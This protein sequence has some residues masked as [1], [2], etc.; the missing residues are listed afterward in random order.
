MERF[1]K[2]AGAALGS[3][4]KTASALGHSYI[5]SEH[6]LLGILSQT[7]SVGAR[8]LLS[9]GITF[10]KVRQRLLE[11]VGSNP[12]TSLTA[13]DMTSRTRHI[14]EQSS[15]FAK[16]HGFSS[17]GTEHIL[18]AIASESGCVAMQLL[19]ALGTDSKT[20]RDCITEKLGLYDIQNAQRTPPKNYKALS[21]YAKNLVALAKEGKIPKLVGRHDE[22]M[23][24]MSILTRHTK[25]NPCL[26]GEPGV[27]KTCIAE[28]L[29]LAI[30]KNDVPEPLTGKQIFMLDLTSMIAGSKYR[31][32]FEERLRAVLDEAE[33]NPEIILFV[34]EIHI[35]VGAGAAEGAIDACNILKPALARGQIKMIGATTLSEYKKHIEKDKALERRFAP[36]KID[37]PTASQTLEILKGLRPSL[38]AHHNVTITDGALYSAITLSSRYIGD[39]FL[40]DKAIDLIDE[41][42][43]SVHINALVQKNEAIRSYRAEVEGYIKSGMYSKASRIQGE[44]AELS[45]DITPVIDKEHIV[46]A[47]SKWTGIPI[48]TLGSGGANRLVTLA[49]TLSE[50]LVGQ[51]AAIE[52]V[53]KTLMFAEA[54]LSDPDKPTASFIFAGP[55]GVGKTELCRL[56]A[57][58]Y[59]GNERALIKLDMSE[60][61]E[62]H[63]I[64]R[65]VGSPPG[66]IGHDDGGMLVERIRNRPYSIVLFDEMEKAHPEVLNILLS[67][68]DDG[69]LT[70]TKGR[71]ASFKNST[72]ILTTNLGSQSVSGIGFENDTK[73]ATLS[74]IKKLLRP[75]LVGRIGKTV[76]FSPL[77]KKSL[78]T[79]IKNTL[80]KLS[81]TLA[82]RNIF[83][84]FDEG[85]V[86][87]VYKVSAAGGSGARNISRIVTDLVAVPIAQ[88]IVSGKIT[89]NGRFV[90]GKDGLLEIQKV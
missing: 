78:E 4:Q 53:C 37:E 29:A 56:L 85:V 89:E 41:S 5:G 66:Y 2:K 65:L 43:S 28:G 33:K 16:G 73:N 12:K 49:D 70:D 22:L 1:S 51:N 8:I 84:E 21:K 81:T 19:S 76:V 68:L 30:A 13:S 52:Q 61:T 45:R 31:G 26:I 23:R 47:L 79:I 67:I 50:H 27:G 83:I 44:M 36:V 64:S 80:S 62:R 48:S 17:I 63:S 7:D 57:K 18:L 35:I 77:D 74:E 25:N 75:E 46:S 90:F 59:I 10:D 82:K 40:P 71:R 60:F 55:T 69:V 34:D 20:L 86:N 6:L 9:R 24:V 39:R 15:I 72:I 32:E 88:D 87:E 54:G 42:A 58:Y 11:L 3:A 38:E 14:I